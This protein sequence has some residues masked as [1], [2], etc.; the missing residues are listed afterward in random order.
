LRD[1]PIG[2]S[3]V[4][5]RFSGDERAYPYDAQRGPSRTQRLAAVVGATLQAIRVAGSTPGS[6]PRH[7]ARRRGSAPTSVT[8]AIAVQ[9]TRTA[10]SQLSRL[11]FRTASSRVATLRRRSFAERRLVTA[12]VLSLVLVASVLAGARPLEPLGATTGSGTGENARIAGLEGPDY[13]AGSA[14]AAGERNDSVD[15]GIAYDA[16]SID[17]ADQSAG[18]QGAPYLPDGTLL[19]PVAVNGTLPNLLR[20]DVTR[21]TVRSGDTLTAIA[22]RFHVSFYTL[23]WANKLTSKDALKVGSE[24]LIPPVTGILWTVKEGDTL[25]SI[26]SATKGDI[27][28]I[29]EFNALTSDQLIIGQEIMVPNGRGDPIPTPKPAPKAVAPKVVSGGTAPSQYSGGTLRWPVAGGYISQYFSS[30]HHAIDIAAPYGTSVMAAAGGKVTW[31]GWRNNCGGYQIWV[32]HGNGMSTGYYHLS[33]ILVGA[34][35]YVARGQQIGRI[36]E[37]GCATG[38]HLHFEVWVGG[39]MY[40][41]GTQVNPLLYL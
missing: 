9:L 22:S 35:S 10:T 33:A 2:L 23:W 39:P 3:R 11:H 8:V 17:Q 32:D 1:V 37:S 25:A 24:L 41:G 12:F 26:A 6:T 7:G 27:G 38:P 34:G 4:V 28:A 5:P 30:Y 21:Y 31:A 36:G 15:A 13:I 29:R 19:K 18:E 16:A 14:P 20:A 40:N